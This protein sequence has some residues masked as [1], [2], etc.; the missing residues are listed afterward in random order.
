[1][2]TEKFYI[3]PNTA[4]PSLEPLL[5]RGTQWPLTAH[6]WKG[7]CGNAERKAVATPPIWVFPAVLTRP[8]LAA[9]TVWDQWKSCLQIISLHNVSL[10]FSTQMFDYSILCIGRV[11]SRC[12]EAQSCVV[13]SAQK[14][15]MWNDSCYSDFKSLR[16]VFFVRELCPH[17]Q[18]WLL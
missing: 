9:L 11:E 10:F 13:K 2:T 4:F 12:S 8:L 6:L 1:M 16:T 5:L 14:T 15:F 18:V 3:F 7:R 17:T